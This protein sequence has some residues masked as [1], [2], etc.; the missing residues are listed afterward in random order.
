MPTRPGNMEN[1]SA[2][3][4]TA[5]YRRLNTFCTEYD[6][7]RSEAVRTLLKQALDQEELV[8]DLVR[9][10]QLMQEENRRLTRLFLKNFGRRID[11]EEI[12][13]MIDQTIDALHAELGEPK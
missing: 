12:Q 1:I 9:Q 8:E 7:K 13:S 2:K 5:L 11:P 6:L 3:V 4:P 10:L